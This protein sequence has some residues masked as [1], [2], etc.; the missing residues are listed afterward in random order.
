M[1]LHRAIHRKELQALGGRHM[2]NITLLEGQEGSEMLG[3]LLCLARI[4]DLNVFRACLKV[5]VWLPDT[6]II[7]FDGPGCWDCNRTRCLTTDSY[8]RFGTEGGTSPAIAQFFLGPG[9]IYRLSYDLENSGGPP[10]AWEAS[11]KT[12]DG[13]PFSVVLES[14]NNSMPFMSRT[15][16]FT[17]IF[18]AN[19]TV[20]Q[21]TFVERQ[22]GHQ[23]SR[24]CSLFIP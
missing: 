10:N 22:V 5:S 24:F 23:P 2:Q 19:T 6:G 21:L 15:R 12:V 3:Q 4:R 14:L 13:P 20:M 18:P 11:V 8:A 17:I 16:I 7:T 9:R 1:L